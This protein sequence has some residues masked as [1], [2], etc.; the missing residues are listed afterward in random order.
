M[1]KELRNLGGLSKT[2]MEVYASAAQSAASYLEFFDSIGYGRRRVLVGNASG[3]AIFD[4]LQSSQQQTQFEKSLRQMKSM[5]L[6][7]SPEAFRQFLR[8]WP[9]TRKT[10]LRIQS[11]WMAAIARLTIALHGGPL[12]QAFINSEKGCGQVRDRSKA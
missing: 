1:G 8:T 9:E 2:E 12:D 10:T 5:R 6:P 11:G 3:T 7:A 4:R